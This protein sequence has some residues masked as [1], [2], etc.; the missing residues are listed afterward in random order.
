MTDLAEKVRNYGIASKDN[1]LSSI[2]EEQ[3]RKIIMTL[4][5]AKGAKKSWCSINYKSHL[6]KLIKLDF[7]TLSRSFFF[8]NLAKKLHLKEL[9]EEIFQ[10]KAKLCGIDFYYN[11][12]SEDPV[13]DWHCDTSYSGKKIVEKFI[14]PKNYS[15]KFF[16]YLTDVS[17]DNGCLSYIPGSNRIAYAIKKG[18]FEGN[19]KYTPYWSLKDFRKTIQIKSNYEYIKKITGEKDLSEFLNRT[20]F[21]ENQKAENYSFDHEMKKGGAVIFD[22]AGIHR[23]SRTR[24]NDRVALRFFYKQIY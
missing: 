23:G 3:A 18:V 22:E 9:A 7:K 1:W 21:A 12:R 2:D 10:K 20:S 13:L 17:K 8:L 15:I 19:I 16:F 5:P 4:K 11:P 14:H 6:I 24:L